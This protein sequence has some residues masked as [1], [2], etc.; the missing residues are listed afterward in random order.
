MLKE[1]APSGPCIPG[2]I[3]LFVNVDEK[4][5]SC[6]RVNETDAMCIGNL[7]KGINYSKALE[8]LNIGSLTSE[9][10]KNC[11]AMCHCIICAKM[12]DAGNCLSKEMKLQ[13]CSRIINSVET[14]MRSI[15]LMKEI[16]LYYKNNVNIYSEIQGEK[17]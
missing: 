16:P 13:Y 14:N 6:E 7:D 3:R 9:N 2:K 12:A 8:L 11:W 1:T 4:L 5:F 15:I 17:R 10:C